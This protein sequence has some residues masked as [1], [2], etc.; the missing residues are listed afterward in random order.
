MELLRSKSDAGVLNAVTASH[1]SPRIVGGMPVPQGKY[2]WMAAL[3]YSGGSPESSQFCG[4]ALIADRWVLTAA[5]C[6]AAVNNISV[7]LGAVHLADDGEQ[8]EVEDVIVH[9]DYDPRTL[10]NDLAL[11]R[12]SSASEQ[13]PIPLI[14]DGD[15]EGLA[16]PG[17]TVTA[18]GWGLTSEGG[19]GSL[20]LMEVSVQVVSNAQANEAYNPYGSTITPNMLAAGVDEGGKDACQGDSG[21]P[22]I[23]RGTGGQRFLAGAT[24]WG[25]GCARP[26]LPGVYTRLSQYRGWITDHAG[27]VT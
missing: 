21:G 13:L 7:F 10:D 26:G 8:I 1:F 11:L 18:I 2:P 5:H 12:L 17:R 15:P 19:V 24:S 23:A 25:I 16:E 14:P 6:P 3:I 9:S 20:D 4:G 27:L 22:L